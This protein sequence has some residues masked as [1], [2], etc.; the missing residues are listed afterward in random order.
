MLWYYSNKRVKQKA[1]MQTRKL[2]HTMRDIRRQMRDQQRNIDHFPLGV[3]HGKVSLTSIFGTTLGLNFALVAFLL[4]SDRLFICQIF[5]RFSSLC[6]SRLSLPGGPPLLYRRA[7]EVIQYT[8]WRASYS[9]VVT[10][11]SVVFDSLFLM[12]SW[13]GWFA[14]NLTSLLNAGKSMGIWKLNVTVPSR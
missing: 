1:I 12:P 10:S 2:H 13:P 8:L 9:R 14:M 3:V 11:A 7:R 6:R 5:K 4:A